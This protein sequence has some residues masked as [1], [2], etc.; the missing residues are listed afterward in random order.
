MTE[1]DGL[2][3]YLR[4]W[5]HESNCVD[6]LVE[7]EPSVD[8]AVTAWV[9]SNRTRD[10][11]LRLETVNGH[12]YKTLASEIASWMISTADGRRLATLQEVARAGE[13]QQHRYE[14]GLF[15]DDG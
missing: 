5:D 6:V 15:E 4:V 13:A 12:E 9:D 11:V 2:G 10:S 8:A 14:A 3:T 1:H 7:H